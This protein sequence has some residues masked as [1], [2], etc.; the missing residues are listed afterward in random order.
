MVPLRFFCSNSCC[1]FFIFFSFNE[2]VVAMFFLLSRS[3][4]LGMINFVGFFS[5]CRYFVIFRYDVF[6][7]F[8]WF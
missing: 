5:C 6:G 8:F 2:V 7:E 3:R 4:N 1:D